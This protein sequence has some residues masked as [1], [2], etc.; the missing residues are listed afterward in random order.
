MGQH[1]KGSEQG[2]LRTPRSA[3]SIQSVLAE[4]EDSARLLELCYFSREPD[5][6]EIMRAIAAMP[7]ETR[8]SLEAFLAMSPEP[9]SI[10]AK[11]DAA[12]RLTL[13]SPQVGQAAAIISYCAEND[14]G[15]K[16][17][18]PN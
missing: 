17:M 16:P 5:L 9:T 11:W 7:E 1:C 8:A 2:R 6:L 15:E 4:C 10:T 14:D 13:A 18:L 3:R 12:G